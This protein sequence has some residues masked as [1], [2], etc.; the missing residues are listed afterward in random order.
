MKRLIEREPVALWEVQLVLNRSHS[1][2]DVV[3]IH[4]QRPK[5]SHPLGRQYLCGSTCHRR[6]RVCQIVGIDRGGVRRSGRCPS[7][8]GRVGVQ[9]VV[10]VL[11][12]LRFR[13]E[14]PSTIGHGAAKWTIPLFI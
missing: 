14:T 5:I 12:D 8:L 4:V 7:S 9:V 10:Y 1:G 11:L 13:S 6:N 3:L 2:A